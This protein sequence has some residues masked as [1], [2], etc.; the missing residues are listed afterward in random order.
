MTRPVREFES[1]RPAGELALGV[2]DRTAQQRANARQHLFEMKRLGHVIIGAGIEAL[3]LVAP[4]IARSKQQHRHGAS[5]A[6]PRFQNGNTVHLGETDVENDR[7]VGLRL[8]EIVPFL[9]VERAI[10]HVTRLGQG[11]RELAVEI[12]IVLDDEEAHVFSCR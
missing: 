11:R 8:A 1:D 12:R 6:P 10:D 7:V 4:A 5:R 2:A 9:A 3:N